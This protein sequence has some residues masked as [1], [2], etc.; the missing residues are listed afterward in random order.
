[1][2]C[3]IDGEGFQLA[4]CDHWINPCDEVGPALSPLSIRMD[5][6]ELRGR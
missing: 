6:D 3:R 1:M 4:L 5:R 2:E